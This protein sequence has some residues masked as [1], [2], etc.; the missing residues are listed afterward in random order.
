MNVIVALVGEDHT[1]EGLP[2][3]ARKV[4]VD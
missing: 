1:E 4:I 3:W 2:K